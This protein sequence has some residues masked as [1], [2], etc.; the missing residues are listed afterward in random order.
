DGMDRMDFV[1]SKMAMILLLSLGSTILVFLT[2]LLTGLIY[3]DEIRDGQMFNGVEFVFAYF[4]DLTAYLTFAF[5]LTVVLKRSA[6]TIFLLLMYRLLELIVI[7]NLPSSLEFM[8]DYFPL[9]SLS[10]LIEIPFP[11]YWFQEI[12]DYLAFTPAMVVIVYIFVFMAAVYYK[13]KK[14]DL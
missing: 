11:R 6:L 5:L 13:L 4:L 14:S 10:T 12:Q 3:T 1:K 7:G 2:G 9:H 8:A